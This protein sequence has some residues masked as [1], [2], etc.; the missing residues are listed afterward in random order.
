MS[1]NPWGGGAGGAG[2]GVAVVWWRGVGD[3]WDTT[4]GIMKGGLEVALEAVVMVVVLLVLVVV[5]V[6]GA[7]D[8]SDAWNTTP[9]SF[10]G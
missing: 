10:Y 6:E 5:V 8:A 2:V 4:P 9:E 1:R 7:V 3:A